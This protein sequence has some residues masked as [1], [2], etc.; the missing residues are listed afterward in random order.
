MDKKDLTI[1]IPCY[2]E[3][4]CIQKSFFELETFIGNNNGIN[5]IFVDDK[6]N[7]RTLSF[8]HAIHERS[9]QK[10]NIRIIENQLNLGKGGAIIAAIEEVET[11]L[12][13]YTDAD[14][15]YDLDNILNF[16]ETI[17]NRQIVVANRVHED[18]MCTIS[19]RLLGTIFFRH[20]ISRI[21]NFIVRRALSLDGRDIQAGLKMCATEDFKH[22][23]GMTSCRDF[24]FD[25]EFIFMA[26]RDGMKLVE[27][28][29]KYNYI[30]RKTS[31]NIISL[32]MKL[33]YTIISIYLRPKADST[34]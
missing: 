16:R 33:L 11:S 28:A 7:D 4:E 15:A 2:N 34:S 29:V 21:Y 23:I 24:S 10:E 6:S 32:S 14:L 27:K 19:P 13:C 8:L 12:V 25:L 5:V 30:S 22:I 18:S 26:Q 1:I 9:P 17:E 20:F 31:V 3:E